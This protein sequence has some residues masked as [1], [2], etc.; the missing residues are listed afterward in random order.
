MTDYQDCPRC[1]VLLLPVNKNGTLRKHVRGYVTSLPKF[2]PIC[3]PYDQRTG[4]E[5]ASQP[6]T[7]TM[8]EHHLKTSEIGCYDC[9]YWQFS[10]EGT[11]VEEFGECHR[12]APL[13]TTRTL[14]DRTKPLRGH[15]PLTDADDFCGDAQPRPQ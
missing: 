1:G 4:D 2:G 14:T 15:W 10:P 5:P 13:P 3:T 12:H 9:A 8:N 11:P 7:Q 6:E